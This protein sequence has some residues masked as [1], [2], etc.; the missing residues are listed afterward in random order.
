M[1]A[2]RIRES[3]MDIALIQLS[4]RCAPPPYLTVVSPQRGEHRRHVRAAGNASARDRL[5]LTRWVRGPSS[6]RRSGG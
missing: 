1:S 4:A 5:A 6:A 2:V 3:F